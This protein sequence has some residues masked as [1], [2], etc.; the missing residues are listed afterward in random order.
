MDVTIGFGLLLFCLLCAALLFLDYWYS[1][2]HSLQTERRIWERESRL[3]GYGRRNAYT[4]TNLPN[5]IGQPIG[6]DTLPETTVECKS[7]FPL[8]GVTLHRA[9]RQTPLMPLE[10]NSYWWPTV[11]GMQTG[12]DG[13][14][15]NGP[16]PPG[17]AA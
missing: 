8:G 10:R 5:G 4:G 15:D 16:I 7:T 3:G 13:A 9:S 14:A 12:T 2:R 17:N 1:Y 11:S 6:G